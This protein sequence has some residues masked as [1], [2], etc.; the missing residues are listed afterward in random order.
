VLVD[1]EEANEDIKEVYEILVCGTGH[2]VTN[3]ISKYTFLDTVKISNGTLMFH[4][5]YK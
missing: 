2:E 4:V 5:F 3:D 1:T